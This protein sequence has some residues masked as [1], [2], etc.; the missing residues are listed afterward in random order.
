MDVQR[1]WDGERPRPAL[2]SDV[3]G[4]LPGDLMARPSQPSPP[5]LLF[6]AALSQRGKCFAIDSEG[7]AVLT[8]QVSARFGQV[9]ASN[10]DRLRDV[11]FVVRIEGL[12]PSQ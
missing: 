8:L 3:L 4:A 6:E 12:E 10:I 9:L 1:L 5:P 2:V 11:S 7:E